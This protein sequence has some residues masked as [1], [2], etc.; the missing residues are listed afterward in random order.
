[1]QEQPVSLTLRYSRALYS[2]WKG[3]RDPDVSKQVGQ[4]QQVDG[5]TVESWIAISS[6][7][8]QSSLHGDAYCFFTWGAAGC[9]C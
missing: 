3:V 4:L 6:V 5:P 2:L 1:M 9:R 7:H 8:A